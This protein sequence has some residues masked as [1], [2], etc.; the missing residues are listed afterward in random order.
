MTCAG[1]VFSNFFSLL[2]YCT[3]KSIYE[4]TVSPQFELQQAKRG[5]FKAF[6]SILLY[7]LQHKLKL[8]ICQMGINQFVMFK[9]ESAYRMFVLWR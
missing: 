9:I 5:L 4:D 7:I 1:G 2:S 6:H 8:T 3:L